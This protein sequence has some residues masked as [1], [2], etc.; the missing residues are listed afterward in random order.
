VGIVRH[1]IRNYIKNMYRPHTVPHQ[2]LW[3]ARMHT[4]KVRAPRC[5]S[6]W[7]DQLQARYPGLIVGRGRDFFLGHHI[8]T[9]SGTHTSSNSIGTGA[10]FLRTKEA[11]AWSWLIFLHK[12][13][14]KVVPVLNKCHTMKTNQGSGII[15]PCIFNLGTSRRW[16]VS[17]M[18]LYFTPGKRA[19]ST[20]PLD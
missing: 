9:S 2:P 8:H 4:H 14:G 3:C 10:S 20:H 15:A 19:P 17:S 16:L 13:K 12:G 5:S 18:H 1:L 11:R 7:S 6:H